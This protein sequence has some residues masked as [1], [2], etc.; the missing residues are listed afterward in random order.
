L[1]SSAGCRCFGTDLVLHAGILAWL[2]AQPSPFLL[3]PV[4][5]FNRI[6]LGYLSFFVLAL[7]VHVAARLG[8]Q[9]WRAGMQ[10]G[11][12]LGASVW[13][14][15]ALGLASI[16]TA[17]W[18]LLVGW[19]LG[20][21]VELGLA[22]ALVGAGLQGVRTRKLWLFV[23]GWCIAAVAVTVLLQNVGLAPPAVLR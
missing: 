22:G 4:Q 9:H 21:T 15:L 18:G 17:P 10:F 14:A 16:S 23:I 19:F 2:Y 8:I 13:G 1:L 12:M 11:L 20:Q 6:P 3:D 5:A 7:L